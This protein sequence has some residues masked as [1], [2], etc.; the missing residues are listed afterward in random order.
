[1]VARLLP[2]DD[3]LKDTDLANAVDELGQQILI[4]DGTRLPWVRINKID[5][6]LTELRIRN[7]LDAVN[8]AGIAVFVVLCRVRVAG[9]LR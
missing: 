8:F 5:V 2:D 4:K 7:R 9:L 1:M 3:R 6:N